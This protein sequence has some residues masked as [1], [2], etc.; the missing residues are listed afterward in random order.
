MITKI[1]KLKRKKG[2]IGGNILIN[3]EKDVIARRD[4]EAI[5]W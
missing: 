4:D 2:I 1:N 3:N 5:C